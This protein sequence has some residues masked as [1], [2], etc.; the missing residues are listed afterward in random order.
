MAHYSYKEMLPILPDCVQTTEYLRAINCGGCN[1]EENG[2]IIVFGVLIYAGLLV[3]AMGLAY[4]V[5]RRKKPTGYQD[6][7]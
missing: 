7:Q 4:F 3:S 5:T 2:R 1:Y 6:H